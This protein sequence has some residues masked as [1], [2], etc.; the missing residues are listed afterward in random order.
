[1]RKLTSPKPQATLTPMAD[2]IRKV[3]HIF[4]LCH[5]SPV[6]RKHVVTHE[7]A[8]FLYCTA[9]SPEWPILADHRARFHSFDQEFFQPLSELLTLV[10]IVSGERCLSFG[11]QVFDSTG[12][13]DG[14]Y[15]PFFSLRSRFREIENWTRSG[16]SASPHRFFCVAR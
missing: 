6:R 10:G 2:N 5:I 11:Q 3:G 12:A 14:S 4:H 7:E 13:G 9:P 1:M 8:T 15:V 16:R